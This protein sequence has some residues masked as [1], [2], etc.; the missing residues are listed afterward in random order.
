MGTMGRV[1]GVRISLPMETNPPLLEPNRALLET[2]RAFLAIQVK[3][4]VEAEPASPA[5]ISQP[6]SDAD[7]TNSVSPQAVLD[8]HFLQLVYDNNVQRALFL[9]EPQAELLLNSAKDRKTV[10]RVGCTRPRHPRVRP[11]RLRN[12]GR[13]A[14][15]AIMLR[16]VDQHVA[17]P[18]NELPAIKR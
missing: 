10:E 9:L 8:R 13:Y 17:N 12:H 5:G 15:A 11:G 3:P 14:M 18:M 4:A 2:N 7:L 6:P 16:A 1:V